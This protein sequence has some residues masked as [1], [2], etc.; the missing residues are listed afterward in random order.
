VTGGA[1]RGAALAAL[2]LGVLSARDLRADP[3]GPAAAGPG[4]THVTIAAAPV[5]GTEAACG[6]GWTEV[7][8]RVDNPGALP[9]K[10]TVEVQ[11]AYGGYYYSSYESHFVAR[12]PFSVEPHA[13]VV[14]HVPVRAQTSASTVSVTARTADGTKL[15]ET[16]VSLGTSAA[17]LLVDVDEP[18]RLSVIMRGWP[19]STAWRPLTS[20]IGTTTALTVGAPATDPATGDPVLPQRAAGY[21]AVTVLV[22][23]SDRLARLQGSELDA[24]VGWVLDGGTLA[25]FPMRP[26]DLRTGVLTTLVG[27]TVT[28]TSAPPVM[29]TLPGA[30]RGSSVPSFGGPFPPAPMPFAPPSI[31]PPSGGATPIGWYVPARATP[32]SPF[33]GT[34]PSA[35]LR[36]KLSGYAGGNLRPTEYGATASY[37]LG[38]VHVLGFDP[39]SSPALEDPW[40]HG[41]VL[42]MVGDAWERHALLAFPL[43]EGERSSNVYEVRRALDPN[44]NFR[45][46]LGVA[47]ILLVLYSILAG[48]LIFMRSYRRGRPLDPLVWVPVA[49]A[50][51][52]A[53]IV[54]IG[55]AGKGWSG[56]ARRLALVEAGAG[57]SRGA[58]HRYRGFFASQTRAMRVR[59]SEPGS[60]VELVAADSRDQGDPVLRLEKE[61]ASLENLTSLPWQ[62]VVVSEDGFTELGGGVAVREQTDGS[63]VV[64]N[65][66]GRRLK[67]VVVWAPKA[68]A[69]WFSTIETGETVIST[70]GRTVFVP[71]GRITV[72]AGARAVHEI[73]S[74]RFQTMLGHA[75]EEMQTRWSAV[76]S[77]AGSS[78]DWWPDDVPVVI[79]EVE[80]GEGVKT[81]AS[82][83]V[84]SDTLLFRVVGEGG[85]T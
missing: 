2:S 55:L 79:G 19:L 62:T 51:C 30:V 24:L 38:Q 65:H 69:S 3:P 12:A 53:L 66:S 23:P 84:E 63:V 68:D 48:P 76:S 28:T 67:N 29:M 78:I 72:T 37:G 60:V 7:V 1:R 82:L 34:G 70:S 39:T 21:A 14:L 85:A 74:S 4:G 20:S 77:A 18:S 8:A 52:F 31:P 54:V 17:P 75:G 59:A 36:P 32:L 40:M 15:A 43:G 46:A 71:S 56:R 80:G 22:I 26:E 27:G 42:D 33:V 64:A 41:R 83:R 35:A 6:D 47:A 44:E 16:T 13:A 73:D 10:G 50:A 9:A 57:M 61:G 45:P 49:S 25:V 81:D 58:V 11:S 5:F